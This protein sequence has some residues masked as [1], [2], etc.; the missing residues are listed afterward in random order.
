M[1]QDSKK[2]R[3]TS[4]E[5]RSEK[6]IFN[7]YA[8]N[9]KYKNYEKIVDDVLGYLREFHDKKTTRKYTYR[10]IFRIINSFFDKM[11][12][13]VIL[14]NCIFVFPFNSAYIFVAQR[15]LKSKSYRYSTL[16]GTGYY[17]IYFVLAPKRRWLK[18]RVFLQLR[19]KWRRRLI[20]EIKSGHK[21]DSYELIINKIKSR[22]ARKLSIPTS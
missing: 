19:G 16:T 7:Q 2:I 6:N 4:E 12:E 15:P 22:H 10:L 21:Y 18:K 1:D 20:Q 8:G 3:K 17:A 13:K 11:L 5:N 14:D 9:G